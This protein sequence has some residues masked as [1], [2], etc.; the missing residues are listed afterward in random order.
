MDQI[1]KL[2]YTAF[3]HA[4]GGRDGAS[5]SSDGRFEGHT[6]NIDVNVRLV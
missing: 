5:R 1:D 4:T 2:L 3:T 6:G